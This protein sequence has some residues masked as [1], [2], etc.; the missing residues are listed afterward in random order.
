MSEAKV[1]VEA[2][3]LQKVFYDFWKRP[4]AKAVNAIDFSIKQG[5]VI[6]LLGPNGS[7]KSTTIKMILG[8]LNPTSGSLKVFGN[9]PSHVQT[10]VNIG[11]LPEETYLYKYLTAEE[12][13][14]FFGS[15][16][17]LSKEQIKHRTADLL[18]MVG[19][20][21]S[22]KRPV[23]EFSKGMARRIGL[24]QALINDPA[25]LILD[26]PTS[27]LDPIGCREMKDIINTLAARGKTIILSSHLL[28]NVEDVCDRVLVMY[29]GKIRAEGDLKTLLNV[30]EKTRITSAKLSPDVLEKVLGIINESLES[31]ESQVDHPTMTLEDYF[32]DVVNKARKEQANTSGA[33]MGSEIASFLSSDSSEEI[34]RVL[35]ETPVEK[36]AEEVVEEIQ[37][38][39]EQ[40]EALST[41]SEK[42]ELPEVETKED[43]DAQNK[44][45]EDLLNDKE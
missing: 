7:G 35:N 45:L 27:G 36:E 10:K 5:E 8:L 44:A 6:G 15:M 32:M 17:R 34:L 21:A 31:N 38:D 13:L 30:E 41:D 11:Y 16:F 39:R 37:P 25:L 42:E 29:G 20:E 43:K 33:E 14:H 22:A 3:G 12:T 9:V 2:I 40:L 28:S 19:M 18:K 23:G 4:K 24:A 26:E 1:I